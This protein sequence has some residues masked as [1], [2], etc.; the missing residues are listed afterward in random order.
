M[1][2]RRGNG[3]GTIRKRSDGRWEGRLQVG[4]KEDKPVLRYFYGRTRREVAEQITQTQEEM[5]E[6]VSPEVAKW[7]VEDYLKHWLENVAKPSV[8]PRTFVGYEMYVRLYLIPHLGGVPLRKLTALEIQGMNTR[9]LEHL[10]ARTVSH[11]LTI[12]KN[13]LNQAVRSGLLPRNVAS[14]VDSPRVARYEIQILTPEQVKALLEAAHG[15][16]Y[17]T[18]YLVAIATGLRMGELF[19]LRWSEVELERARLNVKAALSRKKGSWSLTEP[20]SKSSRRSVVLPFQVVASLKEH[21]L[22]QLEDRLAAGP[23]WQDNDLVFCTRVGTPLAACN[24]HRR[25]FKPLLEKAG[26]PD[27]RFHDLRHTCASL[28]LGQNEH[29]KVVQDLLGHSTISLTMDTYSHLMEGMR[30][31]A[32]QKMESLLGNL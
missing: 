14:L 8:K 4:I 18:L 3:E 12:L 6:G 17:E 26:L 5:G 21:R 2:R 15:D 19:G 27:I 30:R 32:A 1:A 10:S 13:A 11:N 28:L 29:P 20:K 16:R 7:T 22:R 25:S 24:L 9:L 23:D 31:S